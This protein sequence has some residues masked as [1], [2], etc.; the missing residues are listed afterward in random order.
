M[1]HKYDMIVSKAG[2]QKLVYFSPVT[3]VTWSCVKYN[4][5]HTKPV[6]S[7]DVLQNTSAILEATNNQWARWICFVNNVLKLYDCFRLD[8]LDIKHD[9][10]KELVVSIKRLWWFQGTKTRLKIELKS[11]VKTQYKKDFR[12]PVVLCSPGYFL[13]GK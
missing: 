3:K 2:N 9:A 7:L 11:I 12:S 6:L 13:W 4:A 5:F 8:D 10:L 1:K